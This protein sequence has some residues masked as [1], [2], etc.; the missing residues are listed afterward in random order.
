M[1]IRSLIIPFIFM[2]LAMAT[3]CSDAKYRDMNGIIWNTTYSIQYDGN[4][5]LKDSVLRVFDEIDTILNVFNENSYVCRLNQNNA[6]AAPAMFDSIFHLAVEINRL[7]GGAFDPTLG[8]AIRAW[9]F[10]QGHEATSDTLRLDSLRVFTGLEKMKVVNG[11]VIKA[12]R[13]VELNLSG[14]A[15][16]YACDAVAAMFRR[17]GVKN[18]MVEIGGEINAAGLN[19]RGSAWNIAIDR[20]IVSDTI[21][22]EYLT[23]VELKDLSV[24]TSGNYRNF[25]TDDKGSI[26]GHTLNPAT[27]RPTTTNVLSATVID[28]SCARADALATAFMVLGASKGTLLAK[29]HNIAVL[30]VTDT[31]TWTS[32]AILP[33]FDNTSSTNKCK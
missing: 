26:Y 11:R 32:P 15:K 29:Q 21:V 12:D 2:M 28:R 19:A 23:V 4:E 3:G 20:P 5:D 33:Y 6:S 25:H 16:G 9:G 7:T 8:P 22:H 13:R 24:A 14:I 31:G 27:L 30:L 10:G 18:F 1:N 17:N